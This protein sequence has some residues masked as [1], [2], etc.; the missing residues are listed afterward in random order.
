V[1]PALQSI[2]VLPASSSIANGTVQQMIAIGSYSD[3]STQD[4]TEQDIYENKATQWTS[5]KTTTASVSSPGGLVTAKA[6][7]GPVTITAKVTTPLGTVSGVTNLT[8]SLATITSMTVTPANPT[9]GQGLPFQ[10]NA[11]GAFSDGSTQ[12]LTSAPSN[13]WSSSDSNVT[14]SASGLISPVSTSS[15]TISTITS[16]FGSQSPSTTLNVSATQGTIIVTPATPS[17]PFATTQQFTATSNS[18]PPEDLTNLMT[19]TS[20]SNSVASVSATG[21]AT[22]NGTGSTTIT[23]TGPTGSASG[24]TQLTVTGGSLQSIAITPTTAAIAPGTTT[25]FTATGTYSDSSTHD[26]SSLVQWNSSDSSVATV[27]D[28]GSGA[29]VAT[30]LG[31]GTAT[32]GAVFGSVTASTATLTVNSG[33]TPVSIAVTPNPLQVTLGSAPT[34]LKALATFSDGSQQDITS[35]ATWQSSDITKIVVN[36]TGLA[37]SSGTGGATITASFGGAPPGST[38]VT[39]TP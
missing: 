13:A 19:W 29:G 3:G 7:G 32:I 21:L 11:T 10:F 6:I 5:S 14:I 24:Q 22:A 2:T 8:V 35:L 20:A 36:N 37:T 39:V 16:T 25:Q 9:L 27:R 26:V 30:A 28:F 17:I 15:A 33:V 31:S 4:V 12:D 1:N 34:Q 38:L 23:A 18:S